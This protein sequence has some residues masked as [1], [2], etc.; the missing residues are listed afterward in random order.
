MSVGSGTYPV[1]EH[2]DT[3]SLPENIHHLSTTDE[4]I[5]TIY[6]DIQKHAYGNY[7]L[8]K[9]AIIAPLNE[10]NDLHRSES[11]FLFFR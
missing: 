1:D 8:M 9:R 7:W 3:V 2:P 5:N 11:D 6:G 4:L 10:T